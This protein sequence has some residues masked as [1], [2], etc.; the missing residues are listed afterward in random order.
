MKITIL[1]NFIFLLTL[2]NTQLN[3]RNY[4]E[5]EDMKEA[6]LN[7]IDSMQSHNSQYRSLNLFYLSCPEKIVPMLQTLSI[8]ENQ[9]ELFCK[10]IENTMPTFFLPIFILDVSQNEDIITNM[11]KKFFNA[12]TLMSF[13]LD[14]IKIAKLYEKNISVLYSLKNIYL[15]DSD[16]YENILLEFLPAESSLVNKDVF[17]DAN[18]KFL[19]LI[20]FK[21]LEKTK[22][23]LIKD[24][25]LF[26]F[27]IYQMFEQPYEVIQLF[28]NDISYINQM[29]R[30]KYRERRLYLLDNLDNLALKS[31]SIF[32]AEKTHDMLKKLAVEANESLKETPEDTDLNQGEIDDY[33]NLQKFL[34]SDP[35][36]PEEKVKAKMNYRLIN[37]CVKNSGFSS[38]SLEKMYCYF[39]TLDIEDSEFILK[40]EF[41]NNK[42]ARVF[43]ENSI[44][45]MKNFVRLKP[46]Y[47][48]EESEYDEEIYPKFKV[49]LN[50]A[51][52]KFKRAYNK[53]IEKYY[54][55]HFYGLKKN[56]MYYWRS[57]INNFLS[58][59]IFQQ[60]IQPESL[61]TNII[62]YFDFVN[63]NWNNKLTVD[64]F[65]L[66]EFTEKFVTKYHDNLNKFT[67]F[68]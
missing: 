30:L 10:L 66:N 38:Q 23:F 31:L 32:K 4:L 8:P 44:E 41:Y 34:H 46:S 24:N 55:D 13:K 5:M 15:I 33:K 18:D 51:A 2:T 14:N 11:I 48:T 42:L 17:R 3:E 12:Y 56:F 39:V 28:L 65:Q 27:T 26:L 6:V 37:N 58:T 29:F 63:D 9:G 20:I 54:D 36:A 61:Y 49:A 60:G 19:N 22:E 7:D 1:L 21:F 52:L 67:K 53:L 62:N 25:K 59:S 35:Y 50:K 16:F 43:R 68:K 64:F 57:V 47:F 40:N 45:Y